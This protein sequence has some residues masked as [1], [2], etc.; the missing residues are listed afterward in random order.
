MKTSHFTLETLN[1][2]CGAR[3]ARPQLLPSGQKH[4]P[5]LL[6]ILC[7][8][9]IASM[10]L[11][12]NAQ[13]QQAWVARYN[14]GIP[15]GTHQPVKMALDST[16][17]IYVTGFSQNASGGSG[18]VTIKYAPNGNQL[19]AGR[20]DSSGHPSA[21]PAAIAI[22]SS[23]NAIVTGNALT[24]KYDPNGNQLWTAPY[25]GTALACDSLGNIYVAG[26]GTNFNTVKLSPAGS[27]L[28]LI[29]YVDVG[30]TVSQSVLVDNMN[31]V[32]ISGLDS[33]V[34]ES[35]SEFDP[36]QGYYVVSPTVI[37]YGP[38]GN[39]MW[40]VTS[41][42]DVFYVYDDDNLQIEGAALDNA[43]NLYF[44]VNYSGGEPLAYI[45]FKYSTNGSLVWTTG[46]A[47]ANCSD[48][49]AHALAIDR[50]GDVFVTGQN[51][52]FPPN[53]YY[54]IFAY[55]TYKANTNGV[56]VWGNSFPRDPV[57]PSVGTAI[58]VD[59]ANNCYVTGYSYGTNSFNNIVTLKYGPNGN[60]I[61]LQ[62]YSGPGNGNDAGNAIAVDNNGNVYVAG[63]DATTTGGTEII[64]IKYSPVILQPQASGTVLLE[65]QG[66]PG[67]IFAI[68]ASTDLQ[69]WLTVGSATTD[70]N[71]LMQFT[72]TNAPSYPARFYYTLPQ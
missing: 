32:Y 19:W 58:A 23:N 39:Q 25:A 48:D 43:N 54:G 50:A 27:E 70:T 64:L 34:W 45:T 69:S 5:R 41:I 14:N 38:N 46:N 22:D 11:P 66:S 67:E 1:L 16:G 8:V 62:N 18:Y 47:D 3:L 24:I 51:C 7:G 56:W 53:N 17:N 20:Y 44:V 42:I 4:H 31:N 63:Y 21:A 72:D 60:Q 37:K 71:G 35:T 49:L 15:G 13:V 33:F 36:A 55:G 29:T 28:S 40:Q 2:F 65:A 52:Y 6:F 59:S 30:P 61:W 68:Q 9:L 12:V 26:L 57:Q 10:A